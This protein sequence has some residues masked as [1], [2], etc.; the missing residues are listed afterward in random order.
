[1]VDYANLIQTLTSEARVSIQKFVGSRL[2]APLGGVGD[3]AAYQNIFFSKMD[4][5]F[6]HKKKFKSGH[7]YMKDAECAKTNKKSIFRLLVFEIWSFFY[8]NW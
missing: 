1:M 3:E 5:M 7:I 6:F 8:S 4:T 2:A